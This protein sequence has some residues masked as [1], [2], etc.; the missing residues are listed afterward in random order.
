MEKDKCNVIQM[1]SYFDH[2]KQ[3]FE[4]Y[5]G[6][7]TMHLHADVRYKSLDLSLVN[8]EGEAI[9]ARLSPEDSRA[10]YEKLVEL[11]DPKTVA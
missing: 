6:D 8:D 7:I 4:A 11:F 1:S 10:L 2:W 5:S 9:T 3:I